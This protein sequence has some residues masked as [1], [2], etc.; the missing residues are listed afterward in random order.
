MQSIPE[1]I[2]ISSFSMSVS[3]IISCLYIRQLR[4]AERKRLIEFCDEYL[5][6]FEYNIMVQN[7]IREIMIQIYS[8][9]GTFNDKD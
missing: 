3:I 1:I 5:E 6:S 8:Q 9:R 2:F 4:K 7:K